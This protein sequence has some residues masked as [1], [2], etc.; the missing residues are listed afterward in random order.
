M[1]TFY[2]GYAEESAIVAQA[3]LELPADGARDSSE[4]SSMEDPQGTV[5]ELCSARP[6]GAGNYYMWA[7]SSTIF[8]GTVCSSTKRQLPSSTADS[9]TGS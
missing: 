5:E 6:L 4:G 1:R 2:L 7:R 3:V 8:S 9:Q